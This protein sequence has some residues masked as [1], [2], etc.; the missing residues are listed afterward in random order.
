MSVK[1]TVW[2]RK[3]PANGAVADIMTEYVPGTVLLPTFR[4]TCEVEVLPGERFT[5]GGLIP[6]PTFNGMFRGEMV[7]CPANPFRL[8]RVTM[9]VPEEPVAMV[10][11]LGDSDTL[12]LG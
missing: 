10:K 3:P 8:V 4:K 6:I 11:V 5:C 1:V 9:E 7:T 2:V 12:K